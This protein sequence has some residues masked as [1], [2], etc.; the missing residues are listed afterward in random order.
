VVIGAGSAGCVMANRLSKDNSTILLEYGKSDKGHW[1][2]WMIQMPSALTY[3]LKSSK[4]N[5]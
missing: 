3:V 4:Y 5:F 2:S 1:D